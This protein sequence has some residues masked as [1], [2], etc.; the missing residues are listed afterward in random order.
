MKKALIYFSLLGLFAACGEDKTEE[1]VPELKTY[2]D[3]LSY[4]L[5]ADHAGQLVNVGDPNFDKYDKEQIVLGFDM[6]LKNPD[7]YQRECQETIEKMVGPSMREF[8]AQY[9]KEG[10]L[11]IGK[12]MGAVFVSGWK[13]QN[14][15]NEFDIDL[16]KYGFKAAIYKTDTLMDM[17]QQKKLVQEFIT[18][19]SKKRMA[20]SM[21][22]EKPFFDAVKAK[23]GI[24][25]LPEGMYLETIKPGTGGKPNTGDDV[26]VDY[27]LT[28]VKGDT[29]ESSFDAAK[30]GQEVPAFSLN[31]VI[32]GWAVGFPFMKKGGTYRLYVPANMAYGPE[33]GALVFYIVLKD[34]GRP[35]TLV[36]NPMF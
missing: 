16:V 27:I 36:K 11:C 4:S 21:A 32:R 12:I 20:E 22:A 14:V 8:N 35:G 9:V 1:K 5:G 3:Q 7:K 24:Q 15:Y 29:I 30:M 6:G 33:K 31:G 23:K 28:D 2:K 34:F 17:A 10:S 25:A 19:I 26:F 13:Q 18:D